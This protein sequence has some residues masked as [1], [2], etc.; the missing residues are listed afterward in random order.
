[1]KGK[2]LAEEELHELGLEKDVVDE[3]AYKMLE[4]Y[5]ILQKIRRGEEIEAVNSAERN[6]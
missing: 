1:M 2:Y 4:Q 5:C 6:K 3:T